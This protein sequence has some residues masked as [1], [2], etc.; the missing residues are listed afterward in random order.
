MRLVY[1][2]RV[3]DPCSLPCMRI[4]MQQFQNVLD[5]GPG[6]HPDYHIFTKQF[7][8]LFILYHF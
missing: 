8:P 7:N 5:K 6:V 3:A 1:Y 2:F 4:R